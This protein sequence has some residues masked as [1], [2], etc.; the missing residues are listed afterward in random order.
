MA[1]NEWGLKNPE[2]YKEIQKNYYDR[3][4]EQAKLR[5]KRQNLKGK[6]A[7]SMLSDSDKKKCLKKVENMLTSDIW[8]YKLD[9]G[10]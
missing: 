3:T 10:R 8:Y 9:T 7:F 2:R 1:V 4:R 6:I 5:S